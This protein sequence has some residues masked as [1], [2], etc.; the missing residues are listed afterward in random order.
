MFWYSLVSPCLSNDE[1]CTLSLCEVHH[2]ALCCFLD[3]RVVSSA[4]VLQQVERYPA[5]DQQPQLVNDLLSPRGSVTHEAG[6]KRVNISPLVGAA[7]SSNWILFRE[8]YDSYEKLAGKRW[9]R[10]HVRALLE[11]FKY[12]SADALALLHCKHHRSRSFA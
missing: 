12:L 3:I 10:K 9:S 7:F 1:K 4:V 8:V 11:C 6:K 2:V 5:R